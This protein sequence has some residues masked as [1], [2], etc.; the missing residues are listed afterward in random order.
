MIWGREVINF[1]V[2]IRRM[3]AKYEEIIA[4][5]F[6]GALTTAVNWAIYIPLYNL[7]TWPDSV[8]GWSGTISK[9]VAWI[10]AVLFAFFTNK[11][12]V[13]KSRDWSASV[14][15]PEFIKFM[16]CR[17]GSG[18]LEIGFIGLTVDFLRWNGNLMNVLI[19]VLVVILNYIGSKWLFKKA[20]EQG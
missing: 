19:T 16:G 5:L 10:V 20:P 11:P 15:W 17:I 12:F 13:F 6:F 18:L 9:A 1:M 3:Y 8:A 7:V 14:V 4:Y 2:W